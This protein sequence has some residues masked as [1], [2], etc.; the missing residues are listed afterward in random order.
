MVRPTAMQAFSQEKKTNLM[1]ICTEYQISNAI[2]LVQRL[3]KQIVGTIQ[4][5]GGNKKTAYILLTFVE[6]IGDPLVMA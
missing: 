2:F 1:F 4:V 3:T 6:L 5:V